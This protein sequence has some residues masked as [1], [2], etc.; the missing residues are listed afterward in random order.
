MNPRIFIVRGERVVLDSDLARAYAVP[1]KRLNEKVRRYPQRFP[2]DFVFLLSSAEWD[3]LKR[4]IAAA[5][6]GRMPRRKF[7]PYVFTEAGALMA[8][9]RLRSKRAIE[10]SIWLVREFFAQH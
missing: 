2:H 3:S 10:I 5:N 4:Q 6:V 9:G 1:T 7:L 8:A